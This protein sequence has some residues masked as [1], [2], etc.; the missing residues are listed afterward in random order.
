MKRKRP[1][2]L[3]LMRTPYGYSCGLEN[4]FVV[5]FNKMEVIFN[6][7]LDFVTALVLK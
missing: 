6:R 3:I 4:I 5:S 7:L 2:A 1:K